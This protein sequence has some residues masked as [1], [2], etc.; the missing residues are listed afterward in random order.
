MTNVI[1][2]HAGESPPEQW[3][4]SLFLAGPTPRTVDVHSWRPEGLAQIRAPWNQPGSLGGCGPEPRDEVWPEYDHQRT[5]E[6]Y[7]GARCDV[8]LFWIPRGP[9]MPALTTND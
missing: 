8:V 9:G 6:L 1:V 4:A 3:T 5:W 7:W 2:V